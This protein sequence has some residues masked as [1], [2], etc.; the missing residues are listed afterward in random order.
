[1]HIKADLSGVLAESLCIGCGAC[2]IADPTVELRLDPKK[3][4]FE[5]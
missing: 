5:P 4:I 2:A 1:V 3:L